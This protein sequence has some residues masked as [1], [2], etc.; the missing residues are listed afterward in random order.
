MNLHDHRSK[1]RRTCAPATVVTLWQSDIAGWTINHLCRWKWRPVPLLRLVCQRVSTYLPMINEHTWTTYTN[2][3]YNDWY[4]QQDMVETIC[5]SFSAG[6]RSASPSPLVCPW[7]VAKFLKMWSTACAEPCCRCQ[8]CHRLSN[9]VGLPPVKACWNSPDWH[10]HLHFALSN[11]AF[12]RKKHQNMSL[13]IIYIITILM[14]N[15]E[16]SLYFAFGLFKFHQTLDFWL[17]TIHRK[18]ASQN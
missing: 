12:V 16:H 3:R 5:G 13:W 6:S 4:K 2:T 10:G 15:D 1:T 18:V 9:G 14:I 8:P 11:M 17:D 7:N